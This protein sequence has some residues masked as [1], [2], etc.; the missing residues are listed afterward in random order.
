[1]SEDDRELPMLLNSVDIRVDEIVTGL[2]EDSPSCNE[3]ISFEQ[4]L[5]ELAEGFGQRALRTPIVIDGD[6][7]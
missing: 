4:Q 1:V 3:H 7:E 2:F 5:V 6:S